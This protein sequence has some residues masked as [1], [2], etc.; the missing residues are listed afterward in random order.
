MLPRVNLKHATRPGPRVREKRERDTDVREDRTRSMLAP[1]YLAQVNS[2]FVDGLQPAEASHGDGRR[3]GFEGTE[4]EKKEKKS[5][6]RISC[7][8][9]GEKTKHHAR[10]T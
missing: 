2:D 4:Q 6:L 1:S 5:D 8:G 9:G 7:V 3:I 10:S